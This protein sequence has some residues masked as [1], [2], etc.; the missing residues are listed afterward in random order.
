MELFE[1][2]V[3]LLASLEYLPD[4]EFEAVHNYCCKEM[5]QFC[6]AVENFSAAL[7]ATEKTANDLVGKA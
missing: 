4:R 3:E 7:E 2:S 1:A 5:R 6:E